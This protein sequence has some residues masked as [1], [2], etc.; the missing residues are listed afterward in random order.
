MGSANGSQTIPSSLTRALLHLV[1]PTP[2][3]LTGLVAAAY[4]DSVRWA[5]GQ[6]RSMARLAGRQA[7]ESPA[8]RDNPTLVQQPQA[9]RRYS[10]SPVL[11]LDGRRRLR[12]YAAMSSDPRLTPSPP[13]PQR[14]PRFPR[15]PGSTLTPSA[16]SRCG[17][18]PPLSGS[19]RPV[20]RALHA[21]RDAAVERASARMRCPSSTASSSSSH[22]RPMTRLATPD[23]IGGDCR[24]SALSMSPVRPE[25]DDEHSGWRRYPWLLLRARHRAARAGRPSRRRC[26]ASPIPTRTLTMTATR[27]ARSTSTHGAWHCWGCGAKGGAYDA[28]LR[29][30]ALLARRWIS[31]SRMASPSAARPAAQSELAAPAAAA[32]AAHPA[33]STDDRGHHR[34]RGCASTSDTSSAGSAPC[35]VRVAG[36]GAARAAPSSMAPLGR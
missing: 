23:A 11:W 30:G 35:C 2:D 36:G 20:P 29:S 5:A 1:A 31:W 24:R 10:G 28:A 4:A 13:P 17:S 15:R 3:A 33:R 22:F 26:G 25:G 8:G 14:A 27:P 21:R 19:W 32:T 6:P 7:T 12:R 16:W 18:S 34:C 9:G